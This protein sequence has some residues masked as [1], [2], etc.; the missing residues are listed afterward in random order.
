MLQEAVQSLGASEKTIFQI[1]P[2]IDE[3]TLKSLVFF[4]RYWALIWYS[5]DQFGMYLEQKDQVHTDMTWEKLSD[6]IEAYFFPA[7]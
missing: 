1:P 6:V 2:Q 3:N 4:H 7:W 5:I